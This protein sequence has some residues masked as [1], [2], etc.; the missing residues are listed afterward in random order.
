VNSRANGLT[1]AEIAAA[2][3][4]PPEKV[5]AVFNKIKRQVCKQ[6]HYDE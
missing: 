1:D 5:D 6:L 4:I 2:H 3:R